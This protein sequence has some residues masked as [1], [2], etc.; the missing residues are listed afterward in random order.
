MGRDGRWRRDEVG[1]FRRRVTLTEIDLDVDAGC[2]AELC[3]GDP[4]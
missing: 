1:L 4:C 3:L 2:F